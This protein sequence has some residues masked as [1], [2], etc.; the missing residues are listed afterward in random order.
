MKLGIAK[1]ITKQQISQILPWYPEQRLKV[2][3]WMKC[4]S[5]KCMRGT[6]GVYGWKVSSYQCHIE[7]RFVRMCGD[8][9]SISCCQERLKRLLLE[10]NCNQVASIANS[11]Q[12]FQHSSNSTI[13]IG[14]CSRSLMSHKWKTDGWTDRTDTTC[15]FLER[16][17]SPKLFC[18]MFAKGWGECRVLC[19]FD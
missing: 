9:T 7:S 12:E 13:N 19:N 10:V 11:V 3:S 18:L 15:L 17:S 5:W 14:A 2:W 1:Q 4:S 16:V 6:Q 8:D